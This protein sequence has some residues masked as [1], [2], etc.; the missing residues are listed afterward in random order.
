MGL[1]LLVLFGWSSRPPLPSLA[2]N[3]GVSHDAS[4]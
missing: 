3:E 2:R 1:L 4:I